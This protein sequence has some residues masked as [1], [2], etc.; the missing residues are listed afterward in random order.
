[1]AKEN[2]GGSR[3]R[4]KLVELRQRVTDLAADLD[5]A[6]DEEQDEGIHIHVHTGAEAEPT[7]AASAPEQR[8][9]TVDSATEARISGLEEGQKAVL[10][11]VEALTK[12]VT[13]RIPTQDAQGAVQQP[14]GS[15]TAT[16]E[17]HG[18][19]S[20]LER[21]YANLTAQAEILVPGFKVPTFDSKVERKATVD[22]MCALRRSV[23]TQAY[24]SPEGKGLVDSITG[25]ADLG[26]DKMDCTA[27][28]VVFNAAATMKGAANNRA[29]TGDRMGVP[30]ASQ[31]A[32]ASASKKVPSLADINEANAKFW[33]S[34]PVSA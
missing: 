22:S 14:A 28:A 18:D 15:T 31:Q 17:D 16:Q 11:S 2:T 3:P 27:V 9:A 6:V 29:A 4:T 33:A 1:M 21:S 13:E 25:N 8:A 10:A 7:G 20:A 23:L 24:A 34:R 30:Q 32:Q 19:S 12:L 5:A 26:V